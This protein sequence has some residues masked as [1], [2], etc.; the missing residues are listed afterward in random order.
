[1]KN[2]LL[3]LIVFGLVGCA[4]ETH[5][6][7]LQGYSRTDELLIAGYTREQIAQARANGTYEQLV[8]YAR[9][10]GKVQQGYERLRK[11]QR[12]IQA[13]QAEETRQKQYNAYINQKKATCKSYGYSESNGMAQ[14]VEREINAERARLNAQAAQQNR[15]NQENFQRQQQGLKDLADIFRKMG[16][17]NSGQQMQEKPEKVCVYRCNFDTV[18]TTEFICPFQITYKGSVCYLD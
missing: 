11:E 18:T 14:C 6:G 16:E 10:S 15:I 12:N 3:I 1:M 8:Q 13:Q 17:G 7:G 5:H 2:I 9:S 4:L